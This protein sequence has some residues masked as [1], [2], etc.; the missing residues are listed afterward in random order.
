MDF[1]GFPMCLGKSGCRSQP[2]TQGVCR[3]SS[4]LRW[5]STHSNSQAIVRGLHL[6]YGG[7]LVLRHLDHALGPP[8]LLGDRCE[9]AWCFA[10][11]REHVAKRA[12]AKRALLKGIF[13]FILVEIY[14]RYF[15]KPNF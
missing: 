8:G 12:R 13:Y 1:H 9:A 2:P 11:G 10:L 7:Q 3:P 15:L 14:F 4:P 6:R 5:Q